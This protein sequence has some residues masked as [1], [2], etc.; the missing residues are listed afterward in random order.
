MAPKDSKPSKEDTYQ[1]IRSLKD[2]KVYL[3]RMLNSIDEK[4]EAAKKWI[5]SNEKKVVTGYRS[6]I[7]ELKKAEQ[8]NTLHDAIK[9][10]LDADDTAGVI[11]DIHPKGEPRLA[12][13]IE[14]TFSDKSADGYHVLME[15]I[16]KTPLGVP[17]SALKHIDDEAEK[18]IQT[19]KGAH[20]EESQSDAGWWTRMSGKENKTLEQELKAVKS[21][22]LEISMHPAHARAM[23]RS[24][25][26]YINAASLPEYQE[27]YTQG[28]TPDIE[29]LQTQYEDPE[30]VVQMAQND[31]NETL[32]AFTDTIVA[33]T[34]EYKELWD[35]VENAEPSDNSM[36][37]KLSSILEN[38]PDPDKMVQWFS[39]QD[40]SK[41]FMYSLS[42][43]L[44]MSQTFFNCLNI[45]NT[46][47]TEPMIKTTDDAKVFFK[48]TLT[49]VMDKSNPI[50]DSAVDTALHTLSK[51]PENVNL[52]VLMKDTNAF[53]II[54]QSTLSTEKK[55][56]VL[57][58]LMRIANPSAKKMDIK[59][60][61]EFLRVLDKK[62]FSN[63]YS[64]MDKQN[65]SNVQAYIKMMR[66]G[67]N[68]AQEALNNPDKGH[69]SS[70]FL[71]ALEQ[72]ESLRVFGH[73]DI[74]ALLKNA[75]E[76]EKWAEI[77]PTV[78]GILNNDIDGL[79]EVHLTDM[80]KD[81][82]V[83]T[84][85]DGDRLIDHIV[86]NDNPSLLA[87]V[88][89][90]LD[91]PVMRANFL[92]DMSESA[93]PKTLANKYKNLADVLDGEYIEYDDN[94]F[95]NPDDLV[96]IYY[97]N[98][99]VSFLANG[100]THSLDSKIS[101]KQASAIFQNILNRDGFIYI[102]NELVKPENIDFVQTM[103]SKNEEKLL[104]LAE[105]N[106][107]TV[108]MDQ[109]E[110]QAAI[111]QFIEKNDAF[112][113]LGEYLVN[114]DT[115]STIYF[116]GEVV[117]V[118]YEDQCVLSAV[119]T[120]ETKAGILEVLADK[121]H[122][123]QV[124]DTVLNT[125]K[126][127][128]LAYNEE[129]KEITLISGEANYH[130]G[131]KLHMMD[132]STGMI[133]MPGIKISDAKDATALLE[134]LEDK[135]FIIQTDIAIN[136]KSI[137]KISE[138]PSKGMS[139]LVISMSKIDLTCSHLS[140]DDQKSLA[141]KCIEA[142]NMITSGMHSIA[143]TKVQNLWLSEDGQTTYVILNGRSFNIPAI[144]TATIKE[145]TKINSDLISTGYEII[146]PDAMTCA[147]AE[148]ENTIQTNMGG[149]ATSVST[150]DSSLLISTILKN[151]RKETAGRKT[152]VLKL[153]DEMH[154]AARLNPV[155]APNKQALQA[156]RN[157]L[158]TPADVLVFGEGFEQYKTNY[159]ALNV[160][161]P[162]KHPT[163]KNRYSQKLS[164]SKE[165]KDANDNNKAN[166]KYKKK[167][168]FNPRSS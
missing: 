86:K 108:A 133:E 136:P 6:F 101:E 66:P 74:P 114:T 87:N 51:L 152:R 18:D 105:G 103:N 34:L 7:S 102:G 100:R 130:E 44:G 19:A 59:F 47:T 112:L 64:I 132:R 92:R 27:T 153:A 3:S 125:N 156:M 56:N 63:V 166:F 45:V 73:D 161:E 93:S 31:F 150:Q 167:G 91:T 147:Y 23:V 9:V 84:K 62:E 94:K 2:Q 151:A 142:E 58:R 89:S 35:L 165:F 135:G 145:I 13:V 146:A 85:V 122:L 97:S 1:T 164:L 121:D 24:M 155:N 39:E 61:T 158:S 113:N 50:S 127:E 20:E 126:V 141:E 65:F 139:E 157:K 55:D 53:E 144:N 15:L 42:K 162:A 99:R 109:G 32:T 8:T 123:I 118:I 67:V 78:F 10:L 88:L 143:P 12:Q 154:E 137:S 110:T 4:H 68:L 120:E 95:L 96:D 131:Q 72:K 83:N 30:Y 16:Q 134:K 36:D 117:N 159:A 80:V 140:Q 57:L 40:T 76:N 46:L 52:P 104:I 28:E 69:S 98:N 148:T 14:D 82:L 138:T 70:V 60:A 21:D 90:I 160:Q 17:P 149:L 129:E 11:L 116:D 33:Q 77:L 38:T 25:F 128:A 106:T 79:S 54:D 37:T 71:K 43:R 48:D 107:T 41:S 5:A 29:H 111:N 75:L 81:A 163:I 168:T 49:A 124:G 26:D 22:L 119:C 115:F